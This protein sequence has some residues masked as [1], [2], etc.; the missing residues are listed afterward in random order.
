MHLDMNNKYFKQAIRG[1]RSNPSRTFFTTLG[2]MIGIGTVIL[3]L[4]AGEGFKSYINA[5]V[6]AFGSNAVIIQTSLPASTKARSGG[7][8]STSSDPNSPASNA[9]PITTLKI[10]DVEDIKNIPNIKNAY[11]ASIG[12]QVVSYKNVSKN[13]YIFGASAARFDI[14]KGIIEKGRGYSEQEDKALAQVAILGNTIATDLFGDADP[15]GKL[16][17]VGNYNFEVIGVYERKGSLGPMNDDQQVFIPVTTLQKKIQGIDYLIYSVVE[18]VDNSK[19]DTTS[20]DIVDVLRN[21]HYITDPSKDD[22]KVQTSKESLGTFDTILSAV[23]FLLIAI[24][25]I[26]LLVGGVGVMNIMYVIVTE[27][28]GEIGLKKALGARNRDILYEFLIES[29]LLTIIGGVIGIIGGAFGAFIIS[30]IAQSFGLDWDFIIP[31]WGVIL[32]V[33]VSAIIGIVFGV[34]PARNAAR[35]NPIEALNKE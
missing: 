26:S 23:T 20:L 31:L 10:R 1:V 21:N 2:I 15:L 16:I 13:V 35:L 17:R 3:V 12:Q 7:N 33:S 9:V 28:I 27:R 25:S 24:A 11:G 34:F 32:A 19:A 29:A 4:S 30:K 22:F 5:Q 8:T 18:L 6:D 14:D